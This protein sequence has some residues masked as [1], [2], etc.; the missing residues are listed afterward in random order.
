MIVVIERHNAHKYPSLLDQMFQMR[1]RVFGDRLGWDVQVTDGRERDKYDD[2]SPV[3]LLNI[4]EKKQKVVGSMR[5]LPTTGPT[6]LEDFF[7]DTLPPSAQ[8][9]DPTIWECTRFCLDEKLLARGNREELQFASSALIIA[10][11][12]VALRAGIQSIL[13]NFDSTMLRLY[14]QIGC[15]VDVM[16]STSR[17]GRAVF[18]G[19]FPISLSIVS[20]LKRRFYATPS[21]DANI[22]QIMAA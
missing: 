7:S 1:A 22:R 3:Y 10:L 13:G 15:K 5:L 20:K 9:C 8:L 19:S 14:R 16:G 11:G 6:L 12:E 18:L 2:A 21:V 17:Y 4:D